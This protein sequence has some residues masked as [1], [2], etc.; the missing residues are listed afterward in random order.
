MDSDEKEGTQAGQTPLSSG[1][2]VRVLFMDDEEIVRMVAGEMLVTLGYQV[3][4]AENGEDAIARYREAMKQGKRY[5]VVILDLNIAKGMGG[6]AAMKALLKMDPAVKGIVSSGYS[7]DP[8]MVD[9]KRYGFK[10]MIGK[11]YTM[12]DLKAALEEVMGTP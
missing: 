3:H 5:D 4:F 8:G 2:K 7:T 1:G 9:F 10:T 12:K 6:G 11:P